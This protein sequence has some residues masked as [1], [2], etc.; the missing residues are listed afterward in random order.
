MRRQLSGFRAIITGASSGIGHAVALAFLRQGVRVVLVA[1][2]ETRLQTLAEQYPTQT[3]VVAGDITDAIVRHAAISAAKERF[4][5]LD[6]LVNNAGVGAHSP[7]ET[8]DEATLRRLFEVNFFAPVEWLR[9]ALPLLRMGDQPLVVQL[10]SVLGFWGIPD[11]SGYCAAKF[12][13]RGFDE[14]IRGELQAMG[15]DLLTV[16]PGTTRSEFHENA[17]EKRSCPAG[18]TRF[19]SSAE[20]VARRIVRSIQRGDQRLV[21]S[22]FPRL[23]IWISRLFPV[24]FR[25]WTTRIVLKNRR[26]DSE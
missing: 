25:Y 12:A 14:A 23:A 20:S 8:S 22:F 5:G 1:R 18:S 16:S 26:K 7:F 13:L 9:E 21:P 24:T 15:V 4:G 10:D 11:M 3:V 17:I 6:I 2:R 19:A